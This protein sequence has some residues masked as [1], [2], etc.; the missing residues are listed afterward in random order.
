MEFGILDQLDRAGA[1]LPDYFE[2]R[3]KIVYLPRRGQKTVVIGFESPS[4]A[5]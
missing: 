2:D 5:P 4:D 3:L 1:P